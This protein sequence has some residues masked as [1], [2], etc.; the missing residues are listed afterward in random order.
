M[1]RPGG[2]ADKFGNR[3]ESLWAVD[4]ALDHIEGAF[5]DLTFEP[6][7]EEAAGVEFFRTNRS[8]NREY[9]SIKRQQADGNWTISRLTQ[10]TGPSARSILGD[11]IKKIEMGA[12]GTFSSGTSATEL[13]ELTERA[14]AS[15]TL[16]EFQQR[17]SGSGQLSGRF[18]SSIV[19]NCADEG[20]ALAALRH[21]RV[22]TK[23][24][25][26][27]AKDVERRVR[28][29]F[30][31]R[32]GEPIDATS[33]RLL[34][35]DFVY[36]RLGT[37][38]TANSFLTYLEDSDILPLQ[39]GGDSR[40][41]QRMKQLNRLYLDEVNAHLIN[42]AEISRQ[43]STA[44]CAALLDADKSVMLEGLAGG[45]KSCVL[46]Q[47]MEQLDARD[48]P[49]LVIR[50]DRLTEADHSAQAIGARRELPASPVITLGDFA[51]DQ[52]SVLCLDQLDAL[53]IVSARQQL[54]W[55]ALKEMLDEARNYPKMRILFACR[56]FDLQQ[57]S[58]LHALATNV[59]LV[60]RILVGELDANAIQTAIA[61]SGVAAV[62]LSE[63]QM[64][65]LSIPL[66][67]Y[68]FLES[69]RSGPVDF[70]AAGDLFDAFW[71]RKA[72]AVNDL[73]GHSFA[74]SQ[75]IAALCNA[76][77]EREALVAPVYAMD[78]HPEA[79]QAMAS[80]AVVG[81][82]DGRVRFFHESFFDYSFARTFLHTNSDLV[83]WLASDEQ[84]LFRRS[85]VRQVLTFLRDREPNRTRY[86]KTVNGLLEGS[87]IRFHLKKL[88]LD[89]L[90]ALPNPISDEWL[91]VE[92]LEAGLG[93][94]AWNVVRNSAP[95][96]DVLQ[97]LGRWKSWL[98][99]DDEQTN[100][101][102]MLLRMPNVLDTRSA[103]VAE[104]V[105][106]FRGLS[107][108]WRNRL[109]Y[110]VQ[111]GHG[112]V[113]SEM[114]NL[115]MALIADGTLDD[116][117]PG[118][119][120][121]DDWWSLWYESSTQN[122]AFITRV[123]GA[124]F[125]RQ[126]ERAAELG[127]DDPFEGSPELVAH[128]QISADIIEK[129]AARVPRDFVREMFSRFVRFDRINPKQLVSAPSMFGGPNEQLR[130]ALA[131]A[132]GS[133]ARNDP[134]ELDSIMDSGGLSDSKW[135]LTLV[136]RAWSTNPSVYAE[137]IVRF[138]LNRPEQRL[139]IGYDF[140]LGESDIFV[141]VSRTAI[142]AASSAS[143]DES[144]TELENAILRLA[145]D[146]ERENRQ[147]GRT[148]L[149]LLSAL[150]PER[151][152]EVARSRLR[153][154]ERRFPNAPKHGATQP[155]TQRNVVQMVG[156]PISAEAQRRMSDDNWLSAMAEYTSDRSTIRNGRYVG[157][158]LE[159][160]RGLTA[161]VR[162]DPA[163]FAGLADRMSAI[164]PPVYFQAI[165]GG[166]TDNQEGSGRPGTLEQ[167]CLV[168]RRIM[169]LRIFANGG[170]IARA[171]GSL[172]N[173][174]LPDDIV[175]MLCQVALDDPDPATDSWQD[176]DAEMGPINHA[177][178]S[179]RGAAAQELARLLFADT[180]RWNSLKP[181][182]ERLVGDD[183]LSIRS[184]AVDCLRAILDVHRSDA[185]ALFQN[186]AEGADSILGTNNVE[187]FVHHVVFRDYSAIR[188]ILLRMLK[189]SQPAAVRAGARQVALAALWIDEARG[190]ERIVLEM[191]EEA[192]SGAASIYAKNVSDETVGTECEERLCVLFTDE[193][194]VV[195]RE[196]S[197][198]W[199]TLESDQIASRGSLIGAFAQSMGPGDNVGVL[200]HRLQDA[201]TSLP[202]EVCELA[203]QA[204]SAYGPKAASIQFAEAAAAHYLAPVMVRLHEETH[205]SVFRGRI[206][207]AI[208]EMVRAGFYGIDEQLKQQYDR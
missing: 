162:E 138:L 97:G 13:E 184:T 72:K 66:N 42:R 57:D 189:S 116:T 58:Q 118:F 89:W 122:P 35:A 140:S 26:E 183:V 202:A 141:A 76:L 166:L 96:F 200:V 61:A 5:V 44:A 195:R 168:L 132:M 84:P 78:N 115:V 135:M 19:P 81:I 167:V 75:A 74:W 90:G 206:L 131:E 25:P 41:G 153:E 175:Q 10:R 71:E 3:Y 154:L 51:G 177:I 119:A 80:E 111:G 187:T 22:R 106:P 11:L 85:Q 179:A 164:H 98:I 56:S 160:S 24:E 147:V 49:T 14:R 8:G 134:I 130:N 7:G 60:E 28:S 103:A 107:D 63:R 48:V 193:S 157:G 112:Y 120:V 163:R 1:P 181:T 32:T 43:E 87:Q 144:L 52:P 40:V 156:P 169:G 38:L 15:R 53:S 170:D 180:G 94:H 139:T 207:D 203:E 176:F 188:P 186:L 6:V 121:N 16:D 165:L 20:T 171:V 21:L 9:H 27:L 105:A 17:I 46:A 146:W 128:S 33:V 159:L 110:L 133:L 82:E 68:L 204:V 45:G 36:Q 79:L 191:G 65:V 100:R 161:L 174:S 12:E 31:L 2:E 92:G 172:A 158:A 152:G 194:E 190:D 47:V 126:L 192:R 95:W 37:E 93:E 114:E 208:D 104:L 155:Q 196:A 64:R 129:C 185:L 62:L 137:R 142:A 55:V 201:R 73:T 67:L 18:A 127:R 149:A 143:S 182:I 70:A 23:N 125:D 178:N 50:L 83:Q 199:I 30:R 99:A 205:D 150:A 123:L 109:R 117:K 101:A 108:E 34:I 151:M 124:W 148:R 197:K 39:L 145:P 198:C 69:A 113:S 29:M 54:A 136:L 4:A 77:S 102:V 86:L 173:E 59:N 88:V 91:I